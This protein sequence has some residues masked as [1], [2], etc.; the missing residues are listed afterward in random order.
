MLIDRLIQGFGGGGLVAL[1]FIAMR[2]LF[3]AKFL[4]LVI[5]SISA[6]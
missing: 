1:S 6:L 4:P 3:P 2:Q 5:A